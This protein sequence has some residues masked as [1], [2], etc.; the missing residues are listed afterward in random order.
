MEGISIY[1]AAQ[2]N[3]N[4]DNQLNCTVQNIII[5]VN[6][7]DEDTFLEWLPTF[8]LNTDGIDISGK[9]IYFRNL[10]I[11]NFDDA[12]AVKQKFILIKFFDI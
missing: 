11:Q 8:P 5:H 1:N 12:V 2:Y 4:L 6:I 9:N 7:T 10:T 3:I